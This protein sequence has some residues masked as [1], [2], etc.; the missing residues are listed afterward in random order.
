MHYTFTSN[1]KFVCFFC[2]IDSQLAE[3]EIRHNITRWQQSDPDSV[4]A[5]VES[6]LESQQLIH[7]SLRVAVVKRQFLLKLK[8]KY[9]GMP[10][11][12]Y[13]GNQY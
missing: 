13:N 12:N 8:A 1:N 5:R 9:A 10:V 11:V 3:L 4:S 2:S 7:T 6:A